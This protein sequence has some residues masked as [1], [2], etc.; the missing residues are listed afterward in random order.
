[1]K[2]FNIK[3]NKKHIVKLALLT[4]PLLPLATSC[5]DD[6]MEAKPELTVLEGA[7][8]DAPALVLAQVNGLYASMKHGRF[9][10]GRYQIYNDIR[11]EEF[12]NRTSNNVTG[13]SIWNQ[14]GGADEPYL[15]DIWA[16]GYLTINR[17][18]TF[19]QGLDDNAA[20][21]TAAKIPDTD[22]AQYRAEAKFVRALSY[23]SLVQMFAKPYTA[24]NGASP[25]LP[26]RLQAES[27]SENN[28]LA[29]STV[30]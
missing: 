27:N 24:D 28:A 21:M 6:F 23:L 7:N 11:A 26:L 16:R 4:I 10:G 25:G 19:L 15:T 20:K 22:V 29:R 8:F 9:L 17:A 14:T 12:V 5:K 1:M 30:A 13:Y 3:T 2:L 18:N